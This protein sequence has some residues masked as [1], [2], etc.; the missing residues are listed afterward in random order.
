MMMMR[1]RRRRRSG[2][3]KGSLIKLWNSD[4]LH[5]IPLFMQ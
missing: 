2:D 1:R 3:M 5:N 4:Y